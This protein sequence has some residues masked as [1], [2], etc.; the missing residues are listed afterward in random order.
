MSTTKECSAMPAT[1]SMP[2]LRERYSVGIELAMHTTL[3][4]KNNNK[5]DIIHND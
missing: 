1:C 2:H 5:K 3:L 4:F